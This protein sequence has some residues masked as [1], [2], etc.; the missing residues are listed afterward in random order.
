M[1]FPRLWE[2]VSD[3][4]SARITPANVTAVTVLAPVVDKA[5]SRQYLSD[6]LSQDRK[7]DGF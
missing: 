2:P 4:D 7:L 5:T 6:K 1:D 3:I